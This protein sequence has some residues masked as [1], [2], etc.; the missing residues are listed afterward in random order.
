MSNVNCWDRG[1]T[2]KRNNASTNGLWPLTA[3]ASWCWTLNLSPG[4]VLWPGVQCSSWPVIIST[5][6]KA[7]RMDDRWSIKSIFTLIT[8]ILRIKNVQ[9]FA[10]QLH[11]HQV[12]IFGDIWYTVCWP[13]YRCWHCSMVP[14]SVNTTLAARCALPSWAQAG[15]LHCVPAVPD[16]CTHCV[17]CWH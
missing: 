12:W 7:W 14:G 17:Y 6:A 1:V 16:C 10:I 9:R 8:D 2:F 13:F 11:F 4:L 5:P 15:P 3:H